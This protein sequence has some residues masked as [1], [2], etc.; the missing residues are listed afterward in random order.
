M[1]KTEA[2]MAVTA[3]I[4]IGYTGWLLWTMAVAVL[5]WH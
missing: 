5:T 4:V 3:V 1:D 2:A